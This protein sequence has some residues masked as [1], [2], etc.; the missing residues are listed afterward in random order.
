[1]SANADPGR[2][3]LALWRRLS[4]L[5]LG[6]ELFGLV[7]GSLVPYTGALG[8]RVLELEPGFVRAELRDRRGV[9]NHL[10]SVHAL[11]LANLGEMTSGLAMLTALPPGMRGIVLSLH[12]EYAKKA[13][14][15]LVA[16][17]RATPPMV[18]VDTEFDVR[19]EVRDA[20]GDVVATITVRWKLGPVPPAGA[21]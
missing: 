5:P 7:F 20:A 16:E 17:C 1:M 3:V 10:A 6:R 8:A 14:G 15:R 2:R 18:A 4:P 9:R 12:A 11:A 19:A 21:R 13:R